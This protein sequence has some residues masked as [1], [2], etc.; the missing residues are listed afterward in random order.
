MGDTELECEQEM[1]DCQTRLS[2]HPFTAD[3]TDQTNQ[4][5][6]LLGETDNQGLICILILLSEIHSADV[7]NYLCQI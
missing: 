2:T 5:T 6:Q 7:D 4:H 3:N 1:T